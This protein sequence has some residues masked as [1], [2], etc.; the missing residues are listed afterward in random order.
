MMRSVLTLGVAFAVSTFSC[1]C[2][3]QPTSGVVSMQY[4]DKEGQAVTSNGSSTK[5]TTGTKTP[6]QQAHYEQR[7]AEHQARI[8][9]IIAERR[10]STSA[11]AL[12]S[13]AGMTKEEYIRRHQQHLDSILKSQKALRESTTS[14][15]EQSKQIHRERLQKIRNESVARQ[16]GK[17]SATTE[18]R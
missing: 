18:T 10:T 12:P 14:D 2:F 6:E 3:G 7:V 17:T 8:Q 13:T 15:T 16:T 11:G 1:L 4:I 9:A 5:P